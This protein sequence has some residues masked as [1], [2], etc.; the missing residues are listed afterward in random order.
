MNKSL[1]IFRANLDRVRSIHGLYVHF[2]GH[3][4]P[5]IDLSDLL[6]AEMVLIVSALDHFIHELTRLGMMEIWRDDRKATP[7]YNKFSVSLSCATQLA[8]ASEVDAN[9]ETEIRTRHSFQSF[10]HPDK[11]SEAVRLFSPIELWNEIGES[12]GEDPQDLK[13]QLKLIVER[14]HKIAH[15]ADVDPSYPGQR[16]PIDR[17][18]TEDAMAFVERVGK[19]IHK[20]VT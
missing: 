13:T 2:S 14:R 12:L 9:L 18:D 4:T 3:V 1:D 11:I 20:L 19:A 16:W 17:K 10:Q 15:E 5:A 7:A 8:G 6:R